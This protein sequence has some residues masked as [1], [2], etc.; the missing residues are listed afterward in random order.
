LAAALLAL[1]ALAACGSTDTPVGTNFDPLNGDACRMGEEDRGDCVCVG[2]QPPDSAVLKE[3]GRWVCAGQNSVTCSGV[4][5]SGGGRLLVDAD[6]PCEMEWKSCDDGRAYG[7]DCDGLRCQCSVVGY[8]GRSWFTPRCAEMHEANAECGWSLKFPAGASVGNA[9][10]QGYACEHLGEHHGPTNC[11]CVAVGS[12]CADGCQPEWDCAYAGGCGLAWDW[13]SD[14]GILDLSP[15]GTALFG[16]WNNIP[17]DAILRLEAPGF[18]GTWQ[19]A[20]PN[21]H[22]R[23]THSPEAPECDGTFGTY[24]LEMGADCDSLGLTLV[25]DPCP[26]RVAVLD[27]YLGTR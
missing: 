16:P 21:I 17:R 18:V 20:W 24:A 7:V 5:S 26:A 6:R 12:D 2:T 13:R 8:E 14:D 11:K 9:P 10:A 23:S 19:L 27:G 15:H 3:T 4:Y 1:G 22:F 25:S